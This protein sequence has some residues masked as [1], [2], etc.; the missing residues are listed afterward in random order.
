MDHCGGLPRASARLRSLGLC[1]LGLSP[2]WLC[3]LTLCSFSLCSVSLSLGFFCAHY[4]DVPFHFKAGEPFDVTWHIDTRLHT[5]RLGGGWIG[6]PV[7][8]DEFEGLI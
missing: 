6:R 7:L 2:L 4:S 1:T 3:S 5:M 8:L